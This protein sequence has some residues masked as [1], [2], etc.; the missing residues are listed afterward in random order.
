M[1]S[2]VRDASVASMDVD[3]AGGV[4]PKPD[5]VFARSKEMTV[6]LYS[7]L[8][9]EVRLA[10]RNAD[11]A[12]DSY[13]G[14]VDTTTNHSL[15]A[16]WQTCYVWQHTQA[17]TGAPTCY[18]LPCPVDE[19]Q[20]APL[21]ALVPYA[22]AREPGLILLSPLGEIRFW[23]SVSHGLA[24]GAHYNKAALDL[25]PG[26]SA[27]SL[28]RAD[29]QTYIA[30]TSEGRLFRLALTSAGGRPHLAARP[31][32]RPRALTRL[33]SF[34]PTA[35]EPTAPGPV[36]AIALQG[37]DVWALGSQ[38]AQ[39]WALGTDGW[40]ELT[41][42][43]DLAAL[44]GPALLQSTGKEESAEEIDLDL[45]LLDLAVERPNPF[46]S[47]SSSLSMSQSLAHDPT[48]K[49]STRL[50]VLVSYA[51]F[52][53][54]E[55]EEE[56][57][58]RP[59]RMYAVAQVLVGIDSLEVEKVVHVPY[60]STFGA[61][62]APMHPKLQLLDGGAL[63]VVQFG[64]AITICSR[65]NDYKDR[66]TLKSASDRT[67]GVGAGPAHILVLS[68]STML[69]ATLEPTAVV[70]YAGAPEL[71]RSVLA[72]AILYG[73]HPANPLRFA[74]PPAVE[75][76][77]LASGAEALS[78]AVLAGEPELMM[79]AGGDLTSQL[80]VRA[81]RLGFLIGFINE[82]G[83]L[84]KLSSASRIKLAEDA[85][86]LHAASALW[87][88][89]DALLTSNSRAGES[90][91]AAAIDGFASQIGEAGSPDPVRAFFRSHV[92]ELHRL[93]A[94]VEAE[95]RRN[96]AVLADANDVVLT[97]YESALRYRE[98]NG[99]LYGLSPDDLPSPEPWTSSDELL[100]ALHPLWEATRRRATS[101][102][103]SAEDPLAAHVPRLAVILLGAASGRPQRAG[104]MKGVSAD[105]YTAL[106]ALGREDA[107]FAL[108]ERHLDFP[109]LAALCLAHFDPGH[110]DN[111]GVAAFPLSANPHLD[112]IREYMSRWREPFGDALFSWCIEHGELRVLFALE[113]EEGYASDVDA[114]FGRC[115]ERYESVRWVHELGRGRWA[116][117]AGCLLDGAGKE[118]EVSGR[119]LMLSLGKLASIAN[120]QAGAVAD[121]NTLAAFNDGL[122][123][124]DTQRWVL[125]QLEE[126]AGS[127]AVRGRH[128][129]D[130]QAELLARGAASRLHGSAAQARVFRMLV[131]RM[132]RGEALN[133][134]ELA[135]VLSLRDNKSEDDAGS[136]ATALRLL[137]AAG[138]DVPEARKQAAVE[139][140]WRRAYLRDDWY[141]LQ[142]TAG[143]SDAE[144]AARFDRT[145]LARTLDSLLADDMALAHAIVPPAS[146]LRL[147]EP[148]VLAGRFAGA[149]AETL[150]GLRQDAEGEATRLQQVI[151]DCGLEEAFVRAREAAY[152]RG[153]TGAAG[154]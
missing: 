120:Q 136:Y 127:S 43:H 86:K 125:D 25:Q 64:D 32:S 152:A 102:A 110:G 122:D 46:G 9:E 61:G 50:D 3:D 145:A 134:E 22:G 34:W 40:E 76:R 30:G 75:P 74:F 54:E 93:P 138:D 82:N 151:L 94:F 23:D 65:D 144:I 12:R 7:H 5:T 149:D 84:G 101:S 81:D 119:Q 109:G 11:F 147:P 83:V 39:Q 18:I 16:T 62:E 153:L 98:A 56:G 24:G 124:I 13:S 105:A 133:V 137:Y 59:R 140:V 73:A 96:P 80:A 143:V 19:D 113:R 58:G 21:H 66:I 114:F 146:A 139:A 26:E 115:G 27:T 49:R 123:L 89:Y 4:A 100:N 108:A 128:P 33:L 132:L 78:A 67:L 99:A 70:G 72:Q 148:D 47:L 79:G 121:E 31:F 92:A 44:V 116:A 103:S 118:G 6:A 85:E 35:A 8:P 131:R 52:G 71:V 60:Q 117:A 38:R 111:K 104:L 95:A 77:A 97:I 10:L 112:R 48:G 41:R 150:T 51:P 37:R 2:P 69:R 90:V 107:A 129:L 63:F 141:D 126:S 68:A 142:N 87:A 91:L 20:N 14:E 45:E 55:E 28:A 1:M 53:D 15:V 17:L 135:D 154:L 130:R 88:A 29:P 106:K 42:E 57:A 36:A